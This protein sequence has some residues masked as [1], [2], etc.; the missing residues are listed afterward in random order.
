MEVME[1]IKKRFSARKYADKP[2]EQEKLDLI[3]E[4]GRLAPTASNEQLQKHIIVTDKELIQ[5]MVA[6]CKNQ[7]WIA[8]A[9]AVIVECAIGDRTMICGQ[10]ARSM[11]GAIAMSYM[12]L[13]AVSL[14]LQ[15]CWLGW[16]EPDKVREL[17]NIPDNQNHPLNGWFAQPLEGDF[18]GLPPAAGG[19]DCLTTHYHHRQPL[20][21]GCLFLP[22]YSC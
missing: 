7:K 12:M 6:A 1:A 15:S 14:G 8:T 5:K 13:E 11:D 19:I 9:P 4:A 22:I 18:T 20:T 3:T 2:I 21:C 16:Y 17:L 10:S